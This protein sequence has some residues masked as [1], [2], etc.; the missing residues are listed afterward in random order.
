V[1]G[2]VVNVALPAIGRALAGEPSNLQWV[3]NI[4]LLPLGALLLLGGALGDRFGRRLVLVAGVTLFA[5]GSALCA[6]ATDL[7]F[8][9]G[10]RTL[11]GIGGAF[12][13]PNSLAILGGGFSGAV[14]DRAVGIWSAASSITS[15]AGPVLGG[16]IVDYM[17]WRAVFL[18]NL[19]LAAVT[20]LLAY[21]AVPLPA[22]AISEQRLDVAGALSATASLVALT[23]GLTVGSGPGGWSRE[24]LVAL[25]IG[26]LLALLFLLQER[27]LGERAILPLALFGSKDFI[28][29]TLLTFLIYGALAGLFVLVPYVLIDGAGYTGTAAGAALLPL[30]LVMAVASPLMGNVAGRIGAHLPL[31]LGAVVVAAGFLLLLRLGP[32]AS[33]WRDVFP[34]LVVVAAGMGAV[35]APLTSAVLASVDARHTGLA[36]GFN[37]AVARIGG[38]I[39]TA[40]LGGVFA[41][42]GL[43][44]FSE[45]HLAAWAFAIASLLAGGSAYF[46]VRLPNAANR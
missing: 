3:V 39:A 5:A 20:I 16:W 1:D 14:R 9:L 35:A 30:P 6:V 11:Q 18:I 24:A 29:L 28:G 21:L 2:S 33:Y 7:N 27:R 4:Y 37:S 44:L 45:F 41:A 22:R 8:L 25:G 43:E 32:S 40:L 36:S 13:L 38:V 26:F 17:G 46:L 34:A 10:A 12:L 19:P 15:A 42:R 31:S 23:W